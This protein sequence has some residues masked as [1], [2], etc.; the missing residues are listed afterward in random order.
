MDEK[1]K[2]R[3]TCLCMSQGPVDSTD[4]WPVR[5]WVSCKAPRCCWTSARRCWRCAG[6]RYWS[7][8][9]W[10]DQPEPRLRSRSSYSLQWNKTQD[11]AQSLHS[12]PYTQMRPQLECKPNTKYKHSRQIKCFYWYWRRWRWKLWEWRDILKTTLSF[13]G[14]LCT[15]TG[16][17]SPR[18]RSVKSQRLNESTLKRHFIDSIISVIFS[19]YLVLR[20]MFCSLILKWKWEP[21]CLKDWLWK[22]EYRR[23]YNK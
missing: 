12:G 20:C 1:K 19:L 13:E 2:C 9:C 8:P 14:L 15:M 17:S 11:N 6:W 3:C 23:L 5:A 7:S 10:P 21:F 4:L 18:C 22:R 16:N